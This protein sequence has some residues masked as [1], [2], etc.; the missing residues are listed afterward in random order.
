MFI[1]PS[2]SNLTIDAIRSRFCHRLPDGEFYLSFR[3]AP[4]IH[5]VTSSQSHVTM[6]VALRYLG[7]GTRAKHR[8]E[9]EQLSRKIAKCRTGRLSGQRPAYE[10]T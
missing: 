9:R 3:S 4:Q 1:L 2:C 10:V 6:D 8:L 5:L 7:I